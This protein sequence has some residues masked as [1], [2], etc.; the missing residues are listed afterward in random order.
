MNMGH[1]HH[2]MAWHRIEQREAIE[3]TTDKTPKVINI[4]KISHGDK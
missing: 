1:H 3:N 2:P 4:K